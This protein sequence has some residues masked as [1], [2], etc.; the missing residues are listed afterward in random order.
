M[1]DT[2]GQNGQT[3]IAGGGYVNEEGNTVY[4]FEDEQVDGQSYGG[5]FQPT[6]GRGGVQPT[7]YESDPDF[8][9]TRANQAKNAERGG[10]LLANRNVQGHPVDDAIAEHIRGEIQAGR[11]LP[12]GLPDNAES[13]AR[14]GSIVGFYAP[15]A[16]TGG[17]LINVYNIAGEPVAQF[18]NGVQQD[19]S[20]ELFI[21][22]LLALKGLVSMG[23]AAFRIALERQMMRQAMKR[24]ARLTA[25]EA[26]AGISEGSLP[27]GVGDFLA[28]GEAR[29][30]ARRSVAAEAA[31]VG[32][33][34]SAESTAA[35]PEDDPR[36][37]MDES[38]GT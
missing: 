26:S 29:V 21:L 12:P 31:G 19:F 38:S 36:W 7:A 13:I 25:A 3:P 37:T 30:A 27:A 20:I 35:G 32:V 24:E 16:D 1:A 6:N 9:G 33:V 2:N 4:S 15:D 8:V 23:K 14:G 18:V 5:A 17:D 11:M 22:D 10:D 34:A 28:E